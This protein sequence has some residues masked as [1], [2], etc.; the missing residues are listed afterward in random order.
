MI[1]SRTIKEVRIYPVLMIFGTLLL[2]MSHLWSS[3]QEEPPKPIKVTVDLVQNLNFGTFCYSTSS[4]KVIID[5]DGT[6]SSV[7][8]VILISSTTSAARFDIESIPGTLITINNGPDAV[9][10]G[11]GFTMV[12]QIGNSSPGSPFITTGPI[13]VVT[14]GGTL[15]VGTSGANP[16]GIYGGSFSVT[17]IQQ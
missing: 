4:G 6:R 14:I 17:F 8:N 9:L 13:T 10:A 3:A 7:G 12:M 16:P 2:V 11:G 5:P 15:N 1:N